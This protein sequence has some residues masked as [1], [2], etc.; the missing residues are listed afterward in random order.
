MNDSGLSTSKFP[1]GRCTKFQPFGA[2][3]R[4]IWGFGDCTFFTQIHPG[5]QTSHIPQP[6]YAIVSKRLMVSVFVP[7]ILSQRSN[8]LVMN[9]FHDLS[10][11]FYLLIISYPVIGD[12]MVGHFK[13]F[14]STTV[15]ERGQ[16]VLPV[17]LRKR[18]GI[19]A[20]DKLLVL[21]SGHTATGGVFLVKGEVL[22]DLMTKLEQNITQIL[23][24]TDDENRGE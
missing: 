12:G 5:G 6:L 10:E 19:N 16:I 20:G 17:D 2:H 11:K 7:S 1:P 15:G 3:N 18:L 13:F 4:R 21:G 23:K 8:N 22:S 24:E 14:G 9:D